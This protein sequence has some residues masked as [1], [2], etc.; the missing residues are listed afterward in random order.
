LT[1]SKVD[2]VSQW[3]RGD[4]SKWIILEILEIVVFNLKSQ[5]VRR[6]DYLAKFRC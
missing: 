2:D 1:L 6:L 5:K 4:I 3:S